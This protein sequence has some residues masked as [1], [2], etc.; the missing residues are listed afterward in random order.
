[1][2]VTVPKNL[3]VNDEVVGKSRRYQTENKGHGVI[4]EIIGMEQCELTLGI[5]P[6]LHVKVVL[7]IRRKV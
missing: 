3:V 7:S 2:V 6:S 1:M 4:I 5:Q